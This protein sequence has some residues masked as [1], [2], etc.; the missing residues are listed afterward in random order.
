MRQQGAYQS[1]VIDR[2]N[3]LAINLANVNEA[4]GR[5]ERVT[6]YTTLL[7]NGD[8]FYMIAVA[9]ENDYRNYQTAFR[10]VLGSIR[11]ND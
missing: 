10:S 2:R 9:P 8:L 6:V 3:A 1:G 11:I 7:R 5:A 4:T